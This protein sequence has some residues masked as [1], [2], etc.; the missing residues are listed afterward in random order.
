M[1]K[2]QLEG[3]VKSLEIALE[4]LMS[5]AFQVARVAPNYQPAKEQLLT[6]MRMGQEALDRR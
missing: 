2:T 3:R 5:Q 4:A 6:L 1:T